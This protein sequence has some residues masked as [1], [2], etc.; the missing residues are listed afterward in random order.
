MKNTCYQSTALILKPLLLSLV[1]TGCKLYPLGDSHTA[2]YFG[3]HGNG[4]SSGLR[5]N[6]YVPTE[7]RRNNNITIHP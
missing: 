1:L 5:P 2:P 7:V 4:S 3:G 6:L